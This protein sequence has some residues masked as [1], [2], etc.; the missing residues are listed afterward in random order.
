MAFDVIKYLQDINIQY[1]TSGKNVTYGWVNI[2]C[3]LCYDQ[4]SHGGFNIDGSYYNCWLCGGHSLIKV[5]RALENISH[6]EAKKRLETYQ[7]DT[8]SKVRIESPPLKSDIEFPIGTS[9]LKSQHKS[10]L[11]KRG[12]DPDELEGKYHLLGTGP[13]AFVKLGD[14][15]INYSNRIIIPIIYQ[16]KIVSYQGRDITGRSDLRYRTCLRVEEVIHHKHILYNLDN[17]DDTAIIVEGVF[18]VWRFGN[19]AIST[20]GIQYTDEQLLLLLETNIKQAVVM[21]DYEPQAQKQAKK[22]VDTLNHF[23]ISAI[24]YYLTGKDPA[25]LTKQEVKKIKTELNL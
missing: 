21:F 15:K 14:K 9:V 12:F 17:C 11:Q 16:N 13:V 2:G 18:D 20:F 22:L 19:G 10:Y 8:P 4:S 24:N 3:P 6:A 7:T 5:I 1:W 25:E 23:G